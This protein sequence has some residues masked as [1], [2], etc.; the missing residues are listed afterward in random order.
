VAEA[1]LEPRDRKRVQLFLENLAETLAASN[2]PLVNPG[3][4]KG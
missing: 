2:V 3:S 1:E 4:A